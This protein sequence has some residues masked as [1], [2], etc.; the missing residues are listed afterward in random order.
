MLFR[1]FILTVIILVSFFIGWFNI[2]S[3]QIF[4]FHPAPT[5]YQQHKEKRK[6]FKKLRKAYMEQMHRAHPDTDWK[7]MD[8]NTRREKALAKTDLR[9]SVYNS[10]SS[11]ESKT[12]RFSDRDVVGSWAEKGSNN[13]SGRIHTAEIDWENGMIYCG[14]S[15]GNIWR[16]TI[17]GT[18]WE[19][20]NDYFQI[21]D[22]K[23]LRFVE[24]G[25][26]RR[27]L[28][29]S[30][31]K[32]FYYSNDDGFTINQA[33]GLDN[34][35]NWGWVVRTIVK[36]DPLQTI[37]LLAVEW[38]YNA[39]QEIT[40]LHKSVDLGESFQQVHTLTETL[41]GSFDIWQSRYGNSEVYLLNDNN[42]YIIDENDNLVFISNLNVNSSGSS[43]LI[44]GEDN[45]A[46]FL[47]AR[48]G[49]DIYY[50]P[51]GGN[52]WQYKGAQPSGTFS[53]NSFNC[54]NLSSQHVYIGSVDL[55]R[56]V[57][58]ANSWQMVNNWW[59]YYGQEAT[60]LH[61]DIPEVRF[62]VDPEGIEHAY[63]ST[64]GGLY[65]SG[66]YIQTVAN[67]S[68]NGLGVSQ[69]Y[70]TYTSRSYPHNV[71]AGSQDQGYQRSLN[72]QGG[73]LDFEQV[74]SGDY[75]HLVSGDGGESIWCD[76]PGFVLHYPDAAGN[77]NGA[78]W[79]FVGSG[80]LWIPPVIADPLDP[81]VAYV[82]GGGEGG[83]YLIRLQAS[84]N[85]ISHTQMAHDFPYQLSGLA[86]SHIDY[87]YWYTISSNGHFYYSMDAG[88]TWDESNT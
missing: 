18:D 8:E 11:G 65:H 9:R 73:I 17:Y 23:M 41:S 61:A 34:L 57:N 28:I 19:S 3:E 48:V 30:G 66:D 44:G 37:Y 22:I 54:S 7:S 84:G 74:I 46:L 39:W 64:D 45:G 16:G 35:Q 24:R 77:S 6:E 56:S 67:L 5:E 63:I 60:K 70:S 42:L 31:G 81:D 51:N 62:F 50:S 86:I 25:P 13:L 27:L 80:F 49:S 53:N 87:A 59:E 26:D 68:L 1:S 4:G 78:T 2:S 75:G 21:P 85:S 58:G 88:E 32:R 71:F 14:S 38:D 79:D 29:G 36:N 12:A 33:Q 43:I 72:D 69:Y 40:T 52:S 82:A 47:Y 15:G 83:N 10:S 76:Y 20:M 55:Y